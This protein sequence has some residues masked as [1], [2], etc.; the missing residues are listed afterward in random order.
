MQLEL[1]KE[2]YRTLLE[3]IFLGNWILT[4][5]ELD[6]DIETQK[7]DELERYIFYNAKNCGLGEFTDGDDPDDCYPSR[8]FEDNSPV[9]DYIDNYDD[10]AFWEELAYRLAERDLLQRYGEATLT[11]YSSEERF[12]LKEELAN[13]YHRIFRKTGLESITFSNPKKG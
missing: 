2:Q 6:P 13:K 5:M 3:L 11:Q 9:F 7:Y 8:K 1:T 12:L 4:S 10:Q